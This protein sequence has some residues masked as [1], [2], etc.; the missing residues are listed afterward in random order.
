[1][2]KSRAQGCVAIRPFAGSSGEIGSQAFLPKGEW[3]AGANFRYFHS[4][5]HFGGKEEHKHR[6][7]HGTEVINDSY[8]MGLSAS[9]GPTDR[10]VTPLPLPCG[11]HERSSMYERG[12]N[13]PTGLGDRRKTSAQGLGDIRLRLAYWMLER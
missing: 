9:S 7:E 12:G 8:L 4:Y 1:P 5:K 11:Y 10:V 6:V 13:P 3:L 2:L